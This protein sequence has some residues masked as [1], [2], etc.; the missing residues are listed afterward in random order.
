MR[1]SST[2]LVD[3]LGVIVKHTGMPGAYVSAHD[4][5]A[6]L[7]KLP[8]VYGFKDAPYFTGWSDMD[9]FP[10][11]NPSH[12]AYLLGIQKVQKEP[13]KL[14]EYVVQ[15]HCMRS[16]KSCWFESD[17]EFRLSYDKTYPIIRTGRE[18]EIPQ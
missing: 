3:S 11:K 2:P 7:E 4:L 1:N 9:K 8:K 18:V 15:N 17:D 10:N 13:K 5:E 16:A 12:Q 6:A 14:Y